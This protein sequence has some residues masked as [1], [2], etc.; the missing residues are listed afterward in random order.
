MINQLIP[1]SVATEL[2]NSYLQYAISTANRAIPS[3][4]DGLKTVQRRIIQSAFELGLLNS[5]PFKKV[6]R[7]DGYTLGNYHP[8]GSSADAIVSLCDLSSYSN[9]LLEG[10]GNL[11]GFSVTSRQVISANKAAAARYLEVKLAAFSE[12]VFD[13]DTKYLATKA[14][15]DGTKQ[16]VTSFVPALPLALINSQTGIGTG[17]ATNSVGFTAANVAKSIA[18]IN[19]EQLA[20]KALGV[21]DFAHNTNIIKNNELLRLHQEGRANVSLQGEWVI[22]SNYQYSKRSKREAIIVTK[23]ASGNPEKFCEQIKSLVEDNKLELAHIADESSST[24]KI[25]IVCKASQ[26]AAN[27][28]PVLLANTCLKAT[29]SVN[30]TFIVD[31][32][33]KLVT[34]YEI[35]KLWY[36]ARSKALLNKFTTEASQLATELE[37]KE[38]VL[39]VLPNILDVIQTIVTAD[40]TKAAVSSLMS[41]F[42]VTEAVANAIIGLS[43]KQLTKIQ[44]TKLADEI[45]DIKAKL[46]KLELL[47]SEPS[48]LHAEIYRLAMDC[49]KIA[50]SRISQLIN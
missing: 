47:I 36:E 46:E 15:Y 43:L 5:Q 9:P 41:N 6:V 32:L 14:N 40:D 22:E 39:S 20:I 4:V 12:A 1:T 49:V 48:I 38:G 3:A 44:A 19:N 8:N 34:P 29:Y 10:H 21:P 35:L 2:T 16:E 33:P 25:I 28:L 24:I 50:A 26:K 23:L 37:I 42:D 18:F 30:Q 11:G 31:G 45:K 17:Y 13:L 27:V 7:L